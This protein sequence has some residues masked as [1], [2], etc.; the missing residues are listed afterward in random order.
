MFL[1]A[2]F[3]WLVREKTP[4][5]RTILRFASRVFRVGKLSTPWQRTSNYCLQQRALFVLERILFCLDQTPAIVSL[6]PV[7]VHVSACTL[8]WLCL[9]LETQKY[10]VARQYNMCMSSQILCVNVPMPEWNMCAHTF[11]MSTFGCIALAC[12]RVLTCDWRQQVVRVGAVAPWVSFNSKY[13]FF[14]LPPSCDGFIPFTSLF[15]WRSVFW[16]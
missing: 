12:C 8:H 13:L 4:E 10:N 3:L 5:S 6:R 16:G 2:A 15:L 7:S 1:R 14:P 9:C 11:Y